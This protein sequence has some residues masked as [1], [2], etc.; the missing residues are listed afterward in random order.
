MIDEKRLEEH[1]INDEPMLI[2]TLDA[3]E[4][5]ETLSLALKVVQ[6][7]YKACQIYESPSIVEGKEALMFVLLDD[8]LAPFSVAEGEKESK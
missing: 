6:A 2:H 5:Y 3:R 8:A 7:A 1:G 4:L